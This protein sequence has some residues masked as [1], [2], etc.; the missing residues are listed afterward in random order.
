[1][2][3]SLSSKPPVIRRQ[4]KAQSELGA[5]KRR[6]FAPET[7]FAE[8]IIRVRF[9]I[10]VDSL[11]L[12]AT[13]APTPDLPLRDEQALTVY[14]FMGAELTGLDLGRF[15]VFPDPSGYVLQ[16]REDGENYWEWM[17]RP[18]I[19]DALGRNFLAVRLYLPESQSDGVVVRTELDTIS[20]DVEVVGEEPEVQSE[21]ALHSMEPAER[22]GINVFY[23]DQNVLS[24]TFA[25]ETDVSDMTIATDYTEFPILGDFPIFGQT[26]NR[27]PA[28]TCIYYERQGE[29]PVLP[30]LCRS[31]TAYDYPLVPGEIFWYNPNDR[32][33]RDVVI[34]HGGR[35][36]IC[37]ARS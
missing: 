8:D 32:Q 16:I 36:F 15:D 22:Q 29:A 30:R 31:G 7:V 13:P 34:R 33:L 14:R 27:I 11:G 18:K 5:G 20:F 4:L 1:M 35:A 28:N 17:L 2:I 21:Y 9:E 6:L 12:E 37:S 3:F 24:I 23:S 25:N 26:S 10:D 19:P